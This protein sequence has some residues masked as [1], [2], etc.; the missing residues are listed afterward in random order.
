MAEYMVRAGE[1]RNCGGR[2]LYCMAAMG[3]DLSPKRRSALLKRVGDEVSAVVADE[4]LPFEA[5]SV[6]MS[7]VMTVK[8]V[9]VRLY[10]MRAPAGED[11]ERKVLMG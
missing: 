7:K 3:R 11:E 10:D 8:D 6:F 9:A 4:E 5:V 2:E 1:E